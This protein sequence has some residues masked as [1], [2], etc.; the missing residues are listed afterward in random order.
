[1]DLGRMRFEYQL[2]RVKALIEASKQ[3]ESTAIWLYQNDL[4]TPFFM[5]E[6]LSRL[7]AK[8][9]NNKRF[10]KLKERFKSVEDA[11]GQVDY[12]DSL[13][14]EFSTKRSVSKDVKLLYEAKKDESLKQ[15]HKLLKKDDWYNGKR[16]K[17]ITS[18]LKDIDWKTEEREVELFKDIYSK[19]IKEVS[20]L[21]RDKK[22][23]MKNMEDDVHE[24]RRQLRW[25]SIYPHAL[26]GVVKFRNPKKVSNELLAYQTPEV[27]ASPY[28]K[29]RYS[30]E[31]NS[32]LYFSK[33]HFLALSWLLARLGA[34]KDDGLKFESLSH[35]LMET[36]NLSLRQTKLKAY[37]I[38]GKRF[39]KEEDLLK[40]ASQDIKNFFAQN[41]LE[42]LIT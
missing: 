19:E 27:L 3:Q 23:V 29:L 24:I 42:G 21:L 31:L 10:S 8:A 20:D 12:Y 2:N 41:I 16:I 14:R 33:P 40:F 11:L 15:L 37:T 17:K 35:S 30:K 25:M 38:L 32:Y 36:D 9:H 39:P 28:N 18:Q 22:F 26:H 1:M 34:I 13:N 6:G 5:L 7:Y 4:R